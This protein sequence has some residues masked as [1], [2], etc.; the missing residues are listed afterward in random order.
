MIAADLAL[1]LDP[2]EVSRRAGIDPD[3]WQTDVLRSNDP[4]VLLNCSRQSGKSSV[5]ALV[6]VHGA[7]YEPG[8]LQLLLSPSERQSGELFK[9]CSA[10][11]TAL[12]RPVPATSETALTVTLENGS[13][14]VSL[15]GSKEGTIRGYSGVR[16]L[17][18]DE[19]SRVLDDLYNAVMPM[20]A[21]SGG[22][23]LAMSTPW[24]KRGWWHHEWVEGGPDWK[25]IEVPA[26]ACPR[27]SPAFLEEQRRRLPPW[28]FSQ[29][30][31]CAFSET[32]D[33]LFGYDLVMEAMSDEIEPFFPDTVV[34]G[35][36]DDCVLW[37]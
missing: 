33:Q 21:V 5:A 3:P 14:I 1:A 12:G 26:T 22:S 13:R 15:P 11:Y 37:S 32:D 34:A 6:A 31:M 36:D 23:L 25:R 8:T 4:R 24:G 2:V 35:V 20:L 10:A 16:R 27:I 29:E 7:I 18:I 28:W 30:F 19:A 17:I 9:K